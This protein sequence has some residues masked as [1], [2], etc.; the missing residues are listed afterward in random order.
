MKKYFYPLITIKNTN[1][2]NEI[3][4]LLCVWAQ[5]NRNGYWVPK[6]NTSDFHILYLNFKDKVKLNLNFSVHPS[7]Q[8]RSNATCGHATVHI[9]PCTC[10]KGCKARCHLSIR[11]PTERASPLSH[12][13]PDRKALCWVITAM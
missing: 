13:R 5:K 8:N 6:F 12:S 2:E 7:A 4:F 1:K 9:H 11:T 10:C 3:I